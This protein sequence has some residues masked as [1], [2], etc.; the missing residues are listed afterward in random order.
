MLDL[1]TTTLIYFLAFGFIGW[2]LSLII[3]NVTHV[4]S[5]WALF[6]LL[7]TIVCMQS[8]Q[9]YSLNLMQTLFFSLIFLWSLR[10][11][12][13]LTKRNSLT[14][15]FVLIDSRIPL[16]DLDIAMLSYAVEYSLPVTIL[17]TKIDKLKKSKQRSILD[18]LR[19]QISEATN[20]Y[21]FSYIHYSIKDPTSRIKLTHHIHNE[22]LRDE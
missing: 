9:I 20:F 7:G 15:L 21:D 11:F 19:K 6:P 12:A 10:L 13:Y 17:F 18:A 8:I 14:H 1:Y 16:Q 22:V 5:M 4:D 2:I 3:K